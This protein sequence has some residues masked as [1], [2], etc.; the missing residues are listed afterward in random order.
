MR[1]WFACLLLLNVAFLGWARLVD[2]PEPPPLEANKPTVPTTIGH[3]LR[4]NPFM[5]SNQTD[6]IASALRVSGAAAL[7]SPAHV[8]AAIRAWKDRF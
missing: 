3:E 8:L 1:I 6:V 7:P 5:R 4:V 2:R